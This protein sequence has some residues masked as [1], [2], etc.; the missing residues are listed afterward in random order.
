[1]KHKFIVLDPTGHTTTE[2]DYDD[3]AKVEEMRKMFDQLVTKGYMP[4]AG[5]ADSKE[6]EQV[7]TF[8]PQVEETIFLVP[9]SGG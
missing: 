9:I 3:P 6:K 7:K 4:V 5:K 8:D 2:F 1:M